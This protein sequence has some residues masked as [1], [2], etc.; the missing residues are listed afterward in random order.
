MKKLITKMDKKL[1]VISIIMALFG[2]LMI[3]SASSAKAAIYGNPYSIFIKH[4]II[5]VI[6]LI[7]SIIIITIPITAYKRFINLALYGIIIALIF[8]FAYGIAINST[9]RWLDLGFYNFQPSEFA[10]VILIIYMGIYYAKHQKKTNYL[11]LLKPLLYGIIICLLT[12][13]QP[14]FGTTCIMLGIIILVFLSLPI[15][16]ILKGKIIK[17]A[18]GGLLLSFLFF[19][20][21]GRQVLRIEQADRFN[22]LNPC[23]RYKEQSGYQVCNGFIAINNGGLWGVGLGNSTQKFLYLPAAYT[24]FIFPVIIE[25]LGLL[26]GIIIIFLFAFIVYRIIKIAQ[27][28]YHIRN[29]IIAYGVAIYIMLHIFINLTGVLGIMPLTG[30]PLPFLSYGGSYMFSLAI[31]LAIVQRIEIENNTYRRRNLLK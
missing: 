27:G 4:T 16:K 15:N 24:D 10:K 7:V 29:S 3:F 6:C 14:D 11:V 18:I 5:L 12:F 31:A 17:I 1:L 28:S 22:F 21:N 19:L 20:L 8:V 13:M 26:V 2:L 25:E 23:Q 30:V 9:K